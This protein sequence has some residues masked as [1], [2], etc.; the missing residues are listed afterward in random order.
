MG[1]AGSAVNEVLLN[2][3]IVTEVINIGVP[4]KF[5]NHASREEQLNES[6][7]SKTN[8]INK[9]KKFLKNNDLYDVN[10]SSNI[11]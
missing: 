3:N 2:N 5:F 11:E 7:I 10:H 8:I 1:G 4:D 9:I 6:G